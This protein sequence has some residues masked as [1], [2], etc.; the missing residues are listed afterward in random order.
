MDFHKVTFKFSKFC[1][2]IGQKHFA[3]YLKN[4]VFLIQSSE[5]EMQE[6]LLKISYKNQMAQFFERTKKTLILA[7][8]V[9]M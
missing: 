8:Y 4:K 2:E 6:Y 3:P 1:N 9:K 5:R 7:L